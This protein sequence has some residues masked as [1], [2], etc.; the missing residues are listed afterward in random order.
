MDRLHREISREVGLMGV[1]IAIVRVFAVTIR[2]SNG[3]G[4][5]ISG[6]W[7]VVLGSAEASASVSTTWLIAQSPVPDKQPSVNQSS[8]GSRPAQQK[9]RVK[10]LPGILLPDEDGLY[11]VDGHRISRVE[12]LK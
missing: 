11:I 7:L 6:I 5:I 8:P 1:F 12:H 10:V 4:V 2:L 3:L 9:T